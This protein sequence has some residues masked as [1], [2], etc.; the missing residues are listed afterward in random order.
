MKR[1][2]EKNINTKEE[3]ARI[4]KERSGGQF[5]WDDLRRWK[6]LF[7][8]YRGGNFIDIGCLDSPLVNWARFKD[9]DADILGVD[10][11][12]DVVNKRRSK[13]KSINFITGNVYNLP[14]VSSWFDY[15]ILGEVIEHLEYPQKAIDEAFRILRKGGILAL[16]TPLNEA[17]E[18]GAVD[19]DRHLWSFTKEDLEEMLVSYGKTEFKVLR[20]RRRPYKYSFPV[21]IAW[22]VKN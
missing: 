9:K 4:F 13:E 3:Y 16:S 15:V 11:V 7:K 21:I 22:V 17:I 5:Q 18:P 6:C 12:T 1:L 20:S 19:K 10:F 8:K 2:I 14:C